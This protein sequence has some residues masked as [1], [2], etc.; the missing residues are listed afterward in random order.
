MR[1]LIVDNNTIM[2]R[3]ILSLLNVFGYTNIDEAKS[4]SAAME[5]LRENKNNSIISD[6]NMQPMSGLELLRQARTEEELR[7]VRLKVKVQ[8]VIAAKQAGV[9]NHIVKPFKAE[10]L[11]AKVNAVRDDS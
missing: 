10:T 5:C 2:L 11:R 9:N 3:L 1:I 8:N 6:R 4:G 7:E